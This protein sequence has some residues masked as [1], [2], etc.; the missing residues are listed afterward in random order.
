M[1][2]RLYDVKRHLQSIYALYN[3]FY[4]YK[5]FR[6]SHPLFIRKLLFLVRKKIF[7]AGNF[8]N[9]LAGT[10]E[11]A[12]TFVITLLELSGGRKLL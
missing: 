7:L 6:H 12:E 11:K 10:S 2:N 1:R 9:C 4:L 8:C 3:V 5:N